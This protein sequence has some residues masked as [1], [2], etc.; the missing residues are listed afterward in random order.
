ME[1]EKEGTK[2][3]VLSRNKCT[4]SGEKEIEEIISSSCSLPDEAR[5]KTFNSINGRVNKRLTY[6]YTNIYFRFQVQESLG[7]VVIRLT[8][9]SSHVYLHVE[10]TGLVAFSC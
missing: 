2:N 6:Y 1:L 8:V 7:E 4:E 5:A 9:A 3:L 10:K